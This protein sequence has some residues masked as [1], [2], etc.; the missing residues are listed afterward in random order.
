MPKPIKKAKFITLK[1]KTSNKS[2]SENKRKRTDANANTE[3]SLKQT[4]LHPTIQEA[5]NQSN[6][7]TYRKDN[8]KIEDAMLNLKENKEINGLKR[9]FTSID[10]EWIEWCNN[11]CRY[12]SFL[13][14]FALV[15]FPKLKAFSRASADK[16]HRNY[17]NFILLCD[18][19][20]T[21]PTFNTT[22]EREGSIRT[23]WQAMYNA[24]IDD[25]RVG[26]AG[27]V[28]QLLLL[29]QPL[30]HLQP[31]TVESQT[32]NK[33][34]F[35]DEKR[36]RWPIP[37]SFQDLNHLK[38]YSIEDYFRWYLKPKKTFLCEVCV[39]SLI[40]LLLSIFHPNY[41]LRKC[42]TLYL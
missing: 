38:L 40:S 6:R 14:I 18:I 41:A 32:C 7:Y 3:D 28:Q 1:N 37:I 35:V 33:C 9:K 10:M 19:A 12:D 27:F 22:T 5:D 36:T 30:L 29:F 34:S 20:E 13:T 21:L 17:K 23:F 4:K 31:F 25:L 42:K 2:K 8:S 11:S 39:Q 24:K 16:R 26:Q 15:L